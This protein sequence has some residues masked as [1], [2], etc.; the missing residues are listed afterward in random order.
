M[1]DTIHRLARTAAA[2]LTGFA[3]LTGVAAAQNI[4]TLEGIQE[5]GTVRVGV[6]VDFPPFGIMNEN[7]EPDGLDVDVA[8]ALAEKMEVEISIVPVTGPNRIPYLQTGQIDVV[9]ASL[10]ITAARAEQVLFS[11][12][13][14]AIQSVMYARKDLEI[15]SYDDL[16]GLRIGVARA[17]PQDTIVTEEAPENTQIQR[18]DEISAVYQAVLAGQVDGAV[19]SSLVASELDKHIAD[20]HEA[21]FVLY[22]QVQAVAMRLG[23]EELAAS[24]NGFIAEMIESGELNEINRKWLGSDLP[25]LTTDLE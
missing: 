3:L 10:A 19:V 13:Y 12:P 8:K 17:S 11:D 4:L 7:N 22:Q 16:G 21:K 23:S 1:I 2:A 14:S 15:G 6:L 24:I 20:T 9:I 25:E 5:A 18:F